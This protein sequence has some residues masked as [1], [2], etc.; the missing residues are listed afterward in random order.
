MKKVLILITIIFFCNSSIAQDSCEKFLTKGM[1]AYNAG[2]YSEAKGHFNQGLKAN[3]NNANFKE[4]INKCDAK[5]SAKEPPPPLK[6]GNQTG[7]NEWQINC[8]QRWKD[9]KEAYENGKYETAL[10]FFQKGLEEKCTNADFQD[11]ID[12][13]NMKLEKQKAQ[14][15]AEQQKDSIC[16]KLLSDGHAAYSARNYSKAKE[17]FTQGLANNCDSITFSQSITDCDKQLIPR[18][19]KIKESTTKIFK[20]LKNKV[21]SLSPG[22]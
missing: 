9:G 22:K 3:C 7:K 10:V 21:Q 14:E 13:C 20:N 11:Y 6:P 15:Y 8:E 5:I 18:S 2:H 19:T 1:N 12:M 4:W 17:Y 16:N